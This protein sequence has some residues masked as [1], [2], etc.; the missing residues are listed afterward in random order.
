[1]KKFLS[2]FVAVAMVF[3]LF[4]GTFA[5]RAAAAVGLTING[6]TDYAKK[7]STT[8][9]KSWFTGFGAQPLTKNDFTTDAT[10]TYVYNMGDSI[11]ATAIFDTTTAG[12]KYITELVAWD[13]TG[14]N[15][16]V[17]S[18]TAFQNSV[19]AT[20]AANEAYKTYPV[21]IGTGN[22]TF[23]GPYQVRV[24]E[25][26]NGNGIYDAGD[27]E[28]MSTPTL[29]IQYNI[30][31]KTSVIKSCSAF[32]TIEGWITRG[33]GQTV[34]T[35]VIVGITYPVVTATYTIA[36]YYTVAANSSGQFSLT[37]PVDA[38]TQ[39]GNFGVFVR[40][41]YADDAVYPTPPVVPN[42][43]ADKA[44]GMDN[45]AMIYTW[46]SNTPTNLAITASTYYSPVLLYKGVANQ[47]LLLQVV[48]QNGAYVLD[49]AWTIS[50]GALF[51]SAPVE[52]SPGMYHFILNIASPS[53]GDVRLTASRTIY[54][55]TVTS[56]VIINLRDLG[57][58]NPYVDVN[59]D[60]NSYG[61]PNGYAAT[62]TLDCKT[63]RYVYDKLP[64]TI[65]NALDITVNYWQPLDPENWYV[66]DFT[67]TIS[68]PVRELTSSFS[69]TGSG[70]FI[71]QKA[72][73]IAVSISMTMWERINKSTTGP[74]HDWFSGGGWT[75][76]TIDTTYYHGTFDGNAKSWNPDPANACCRT[77]AKTFDICEVKSCSLVGVTV[78]GA[79]VTSA[80]S[81]VVGK[82][83]DLVV[84]VSGANAPAGLSCGCNTKIIHVYMQSC[85]S[86]VSAPVTNAFTY[87][88]W[89]GNSQTVSEL[90][91]NGITGSSLKRTPDHPFSP[92]TYLNGVNVMLPDDGTVTLQDT[93]TGAVVVDNCEKLTF[94][95]ITFNRADASSPCSYKLVVEVFGLN[96][97]FDSCGNMYVS[98]PFISE[99]LNDI[100][101][102]PVITTLTTTPTVYEMGTDP[103][104]LLAGVPATIEITN[105][106]FSATTTTGLWSAVAASYSFN[107]T[108]DY[109]LSGFPTM[110]MSTTA[111]GYKFS[112]SCGFPQAGSLVITLTSWLTKYCNAKETMSFTLK[113][114]LPAFAVQIG[115]KD[116]SKIPNDHII[117]E[118]MAEN[119]YVVPT[120]PRADGHHDFTT[121]TTWKLSVAAVVNDCGLVT[122]AVCG[123]PPA[124]GCTTPS[125]IKVYGLDNP[126]LEDAPQFELYLEETCGTQVLID[127]FTLVSGSVKISPTEVP[128]TIPA[129]ATHIVF[130]VKDA[131]GHGAPD[132]TVDI[133]GTYVGGAG[134][135]GYNFVAGEA[136]TDNNG[137]ADWAFVPPYSGKYY[138]SITDHT[139]SCLTDLVPC[140]WS[141]SLPDAEIVAKY[142]APVVDTTAP[143]VTITA[144]LDGS[145][146]TSS[147]FNLTGKVTD[148]VGV[149]QLFVGFNKVDV[150]PDGSFMVA[151]KLVEGANTITVVAYDAAG[152]KGTATAKVTYTAPVDTSIV[153]VLTIGADIVS[154]NGKATSIDAAPEIVASRTFVP[155]RFIAEA[156]GAT[157][158]WLAE[159]QGITI[160][161]GDHTIGL[162]IG[163]ETAVIDGTIDS[164]PAAP[165]IK[166]G[167]TMVPLRVISEAFGGNVVWDPSART[168]TI[169]Y[170]P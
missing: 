2:I 88:D 108:P 114:V 157:V 31:F 164:L 166:N 159:T 24:Y 156:F 59:A 126:N 67:P 135:S 64:C 26:V 152:N 117:T 104:D 151:L 87:D 56:T 20:G 105:P 142:M 76:G 39:I 63:G 150:L 121:D 3:S 30:T 16:V 138:V 45:D 116:L 168:I 51:A 125:P 32:N 127:T 72:G 153:I 9:V 79:N 50:A 83:A 61:G 55:V 12:G 106:M 144:G 18:V 33:N 48:D 60:E 27:T 84:N 19:Q 120:D 66:Y 96:R 136:I 65:G 82:K 44:D 132:V 23:D 107:G 38:T 8:N 122:S 41:G 47:P 137:E 111:T 140:G 109:L 95:N 42:V 78:E 11:H 158:E 112:F 161:L 134:A 25:D 169:T 154:V 89:S 155:M 36:A 149:T 141:F 28:L 143:V 90:W 14:F 34:L 167:R 68:G 13:G 43:T 29:Y 147:T 69:T 5:P 6:V 85:V 58:F 52:V 1:M 62:P 129:S 139:T 103:T 22:V 21:Q 119:I 163:N 115:L 73:K 70:D 53:T 97:S 46:L 148:N 102:T 123:A 165:Y 37:F 4:A 86:G 113:V 93:T 92:D 145:K 35:P 91:Y 128:F 49:A 75:L 10:H 54:G 133:E 170:Q 160:T 57:S 94:K 40:D 146:V 15:K 162:Q 80:T 77:Y 74:C 124:A 99:T 100:A 98:Y 71:V 81:I 118:G 17:D 131:H 130:S 110:T 101:I 7:T